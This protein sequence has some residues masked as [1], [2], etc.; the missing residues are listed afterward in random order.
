[1]EACVKKPSC[2][3]LLLSKVQLKEYLAHLNVARKD[4]DGQY[5]TR[6]CK[7]TGRKTAERYYG[8]NS[9]QFSCCLTFSYWQLSFIRSAANSVYERHCR[10]DHHLQVLNINAGCMLPGSCQNSNFTTVLMSEIII[11]LK[12]IIRKDKIKLY[13]SQWESPSGS[14]QKVD[15]AAKVKKKTIE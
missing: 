4:P 7:D 15:R 3:L 9:S 11:I 6:D 12:N 8:H 2:S 13:Q 14:Q 10:H 1:M 5:F